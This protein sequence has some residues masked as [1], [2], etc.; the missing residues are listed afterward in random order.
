M[1]KEDQYVRHLASIKKAGIDYKRIEDVGEYIESIKR[2]KK[3]DNKPISDATVKLYIV[4]TEWWYKKE[5]KIREELKKYREEISKVIKERINENKLS[6]SESKNYIKWDEVIKVYKEEKEKEKRSKNKEINFIILANYVLLPP[7]RLKDYAEMWIKEEGEEEES[8]KN[9]YDKKKGSMI[10][11]NYKTSKYYKTKEFGLSEEHNEI[12]RGYIERN[13]VKGKLLGEQST[14]TIQYRLA[15]IFKRATGKRV[16]VNI[17]RH[18]YI[19]WLKESGEILGIENR[20]S[21]I[22]GH[23]ATRQ[24][25]YY[26]NTTG[27]RSKVLDGIKIIR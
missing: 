3:K 17:L 9:Y 21:E 4:S 12:I 26:K 10:F 8:G 14:T 15:R 16:S 11:S 25:E 18:S 24:N 23:G 20:L 27:K 6:E 2:I 7:R 1:K 22:M 13:K 19:S 5:E